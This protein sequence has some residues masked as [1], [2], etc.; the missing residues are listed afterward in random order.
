MVH[1]RGPSLVSLLCVLILVTATQYRGAIASQVDVLNEQQAMVLDGNYA[2]RVSVVAALNEP[3]AP[4]GPLVAMARSVVNI[5]TTPRFTDVENARS[6]FRARQLFELVTVYGDLD[7]L[8]AARAAMRASETEMNPLDDLKI[9]SALDA[10][11]ER[12]VVAANKIIEGISAFKQA[13]ANWLRALGA[14][15]QRKLAVALKYAKLSVQ[16]DENHPHAYPLYVSLKAKTSEPVDGLEAYR[17]L[18]EQIRPQHISSQIGFER[19]RITTKK[20]VVEAAQNLGRLLR[21]KVTL[22]GPRQRALIYEGLGRHHLATG[23]TDSAKSAFVAA[24]DAVPGDPV[25]VEP[26]ALLHMREFRL[27]SAMSLVERLSEEARSQLYPPGSIGL[28]EGNAL[29]A[30][31]LLDREM[32]PSARTFFLQG[33]ARLELTEDLNLETGERLRWLREAR[34]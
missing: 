21:S 20:R 32:S 10:L 25:F 22:L 1:D 7:R 24:T 31:E 28:D 14:L 4:V 29:G 34:T 5:F 16:A 18:V 2:S 9:A 12:E 6:A 19:L 13:D 27:D 26:L 3:P 17:R 33:M 15:E 8:G 23:R 30:I 11:H